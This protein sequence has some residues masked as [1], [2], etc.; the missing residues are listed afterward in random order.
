MLGDYY[1]KAFDK[2]NISKDESYE[3]SINK[4]NI[5]NISFI[6]QKSLS[7]NIMIKIHYLMWLP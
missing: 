1:S 7:F 2:L 3:E 6:L 4:Y 5:I